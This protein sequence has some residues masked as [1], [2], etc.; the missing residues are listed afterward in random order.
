MPHAAVLPP[1]E[2]T[3]RSPLLS[4]FAAP[5]TT[6]IQGEADCP[7]VKT[8]SAR[9]LPRHI[10]LP[11]FTHETMSL[12]R[13]FFFS[14]SRPHLTERPREDLNINAIRVSQTR[15]QLGESSLCVCGGGGR[16]TRG[17]AR[18][19]IHEGRPLTGMGQ[20]GTAEHPRSPTGVARDVCI[21]VKGR[22]GGQL[23]LSEKVVNI[24][25]GSS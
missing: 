4:R 3:A 5:G 12:R 11:S 22:E 25:S 15:T 2:A 13:F 6:R 20:V 19:I 1:P 17:S 18:N 23:S 14:F 9:S 7:L 10:R 24:V 16:V 21:L 8:R